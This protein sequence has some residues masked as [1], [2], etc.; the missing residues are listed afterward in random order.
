VKDRHVGCLK[1]RRP[2][3]ALEVQNVIYV[4]LNAGILN[5]LVER[6]DL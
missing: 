3:I 5:K 4:R 6:S 1:K 2:P